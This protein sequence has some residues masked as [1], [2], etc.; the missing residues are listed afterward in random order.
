MSGLTAQLRLAER[1]V[2]LALDLAPGEVLAMLG[3]NGA[4]K[5]TVLSLIAGLLSPDEGRIELDGGT[6]IDTKAGISV[7]AHRRGVALLSQ[8]ALLFPHLTAE[9]NVAFAPRSAGCGR[10]ESK[11]IAQRW[12]R[13][14]DATEL[15]QRRPRELSGGQAQRIAV[16]RALAA[17]PRLLL[18]DEPLS[19]LDVA[20]APA[21]RVLLR[22]VL[23]EARCTAVIVTHDILDALALAD[24][25]VVLD[26][27][28]IVESGPVHDVLAR[29]RSGF[30]A[31]IA[32]LDLIEGRLNGNILTTPDG[33]R[34]T[35]TAGASTA[36]G[37]SGVAVFAPS[38][39]AI[40]LRVPEGSPRNVF[41]VVIRELEA[42]G[43][44]IRVRGETESHLDLSADVTAASVAAL[45]LVP[46]TAAY[47]V[48]KATEVALHP[49]H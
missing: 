25:V 24:R 29:P 21:L 32:G 39:V 35:G 4:G 13:A 3:P 10:H 12:L 1:G 8:D 23:R 2:D 38:A 7:A 9:A 26:G 33:V 43:P 22:R 46:G 15:A 19:A 5:S 31:R 37:S 6:L 48:V 44:V 47:F 11:E 17:D 18:L 16:A 30:A 20:A 40:H 49:A 42:R 45:D 14:V 27:G 28:R 34:V 41:P 36:S